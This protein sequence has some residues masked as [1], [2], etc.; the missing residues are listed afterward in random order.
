ML[1]T[2]SSPL[3]VTATS[4]GATSA[5]NC[6]VSTLPAVA[7]SSTI[8]S[9]PLP[10]PNRYV[11]LPAPP[12]SVSSP[13]PPPSRSSPGPPTSTGVSV[14]PVVPTPVPPAPDVP[15]PPTP[16]AG[17]HGPRPA[18]RL[19]QI[20]HLRPPRASAED[21]GVAAGTAVHCVVAVPPIQHIVPPQPHQDIAGPKRPDDVIAVVKAD[22]RGRPR[23]RIR[24]TPCEIL[25][26]RH[27]PCRAVRE[28]DL[29][30]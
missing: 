28:H 12:I 11:S 8:V 21:I 4:L 9:W 13:G 2:R 22:K 3:P 15:P 16:A 29:L 25:K 27:I 24:H 1:S 18:P 20:T 10:R 19:G 30:D 17:P 14:G 5:E 6:T 23:I 7:S 26:G